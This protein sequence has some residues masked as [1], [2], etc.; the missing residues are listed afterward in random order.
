MVRLATVFVAVAFVLALAIGCMTEP[1]VAPAK[2]PQP[3]A[4]AQAKAGPSPT[5]APVAPAAS[6]R[7]GS[8]MVAKSER[9][10]ASTG[11]GRDV[12][13]DLN[14][15][16]APVYKSRT[17]GE[18]TQ[19]T[20]TRVGGDTDVDVSPTE[21]LIAF[22]SDRHAKNHNV[23]VKSSAGTVITQKTF[24]PFDCIQ[25]VFSPDGARVAYASNKN[26]NYDIWI[27]ET[28]ANGS[29]VQVTFG[30]EDDMHPSWAPDGV[31]LV[32]C[33]YSSRTA[34]WSVMQSN[35]RTGELR[36]LGPGKF[37]SV[38]PDGT[39]ILFQRARERDGFWCSIWTMNTDGTNQ[40]EIV[41]S[42]DWAAINPCWSPDGQFI[43]FATVNKSPEAKLEER[44]W[45]GDGIYV[46]ATNGRELIQVTYDTAPDWEPSWSPRDGRIYFVSERNGFRNI[47]NVKSPV[48][49][50]ASAPKTESAPAPQ[51]EAA[52]VAQPA[53]A[54]AI[55]MPPVASAP[56]APAPMAPVPMAP[57]PMAPALAPAVT[58]VS[59]G[60]TAPVGPA[61]SAHNPVPAQ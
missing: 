28:H 25:P 20:F 34:E 19:V 52:P 56:M 35:V 36:D 13:R 1:K 49:V 59:T 48:D 30:D 37:P 9:Y 8:D 7:P 46:V 41:S 60:P 54:P 3:K 31:N 2:P 21:D 18:L 24:G 32:Y 5:A 45:R 61:A 39:K 12:I 40:T 11:A 50:V 33:S 44:I 51:P 15:P 53:A 14:S 29:A 23:Y 43:A 27:V 42:A 4:K 57:A 47:W 55:P 26:G 16:I 38:S 58:A 17:F 22:S 10:K 6:P